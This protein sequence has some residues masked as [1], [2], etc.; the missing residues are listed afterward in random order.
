MPFKID[1]T[2]LNPALLA[3]GRETAKRLRVADHLHFA[4]G[5][6]NRW[7]PAHTYDFILANQSLHHVTELE[8]LLD[9]IAGVL[10]TEGKIILSD[11]IGRNRHRHRRWPAALDRLWEFWSEHPPFYHYNLRFDCYET[12]Q[13]DR[14]YSQMGIEGFPAGDI[15]PLL[16]E[17]FAF[18]FFYG[19]GNRIDP[20][21]D[22]ALG[23]HFDPQQDWGREFNGR[24]HEADRSRP[25]WR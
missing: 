21:I 14:D 17:R 19:F 8:R 1:C 25:I 23:P 9:F 16:H 13:V 3:R 7:Q 5:D 11:M 15:L 24:V 20:F 12:W 10:A 22:R 2:D 18:E 4:E 6:L